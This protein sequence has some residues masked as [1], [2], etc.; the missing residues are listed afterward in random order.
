LLLQGYYI[1]YPYSWYCIGPMP[2]IGGWGGNN[3]GR[4][5]VIK[6]DPNDGNTIYLGTGN[7]GIMKTTDGGYNWS[8]ITDYLPSLS[9]GAIAIDPNNSNII[10]YGTGEAV[11][12]VIYT[13][14]GLGIFKTT[15]GGQQW[16]QLS[17]GNIPISG[18]K[19]Y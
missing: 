15:N 17:D 11:M 18:T 13:Y 10:Y 3:S 5:S 2:I 12:G 14:L 1:D 19:I 6:Y 16:F 7:G 9:S 4:G 8:P